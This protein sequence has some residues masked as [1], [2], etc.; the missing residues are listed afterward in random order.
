M[1]RSASRFAT[2][3]ATAAALLVGVLPGSAG[4]TD[5]EPREPSKDSVVYRS[6]TVIDAEPSRIWQLLVDLPGYE[7]WN[8]FVV[9]AQGRSE[10]GASVKVQ[11]MLGAHRMPAD[12]IVLKVDTEKRFCW[13]DAGWNAWFVY[14][15][16]CRTLVPQPDGTIQVTNELLLD[17]ALSGSADWA[18]GQA[19]RDGMA[20]ENAA[21]KRVAEAR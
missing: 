6:Q 1:R 10:P 13:K 19:M 18:M 17:G 4:S 5:L 3:A 12:H 20:A 16:R 9:W 7:S 14:G 21:L 2:I 11:V 8:P 15:Q